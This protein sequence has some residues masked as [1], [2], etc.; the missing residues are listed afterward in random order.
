MVVIQA[1]ALRR[2]VL[3]LWGAISLPYLYLLQIGSSQTS[4]IYAMVSYAILTLAG[5]FAANA[6]ERLFKVK[7]TIGN[8]HRW[9]MLVYT[10]LKIPVFSILIGLAVLAGLYFK[11]TV[12]TYL[13]IAAVFVG[14]FGF[15]Y[16]LSH[17]YETIYE[18]SESNAL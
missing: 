18:F 3:M 13:I 5:V 1:G 9:W 8:R 17:T 4:G 7:Q 6:G 11:G 10:M 12:G 14:Q 16:L 15:L 2:S